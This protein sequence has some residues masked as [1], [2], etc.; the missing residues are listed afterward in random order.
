[1][2]YYGTIGSNRDT[3]VIVRKMAKVDWLEEPAPAMESI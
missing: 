3:F 2:N 1:L